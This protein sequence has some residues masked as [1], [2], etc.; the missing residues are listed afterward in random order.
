MKEK[1]NMK[2]LFTLCGRAGSKGC[3]NKNIRDFLGHP[4]FFYSIN[5]IEK[6][7]EKNDV[8]YRIG[9]STDSPDFINLIPNKEKIVVIKRSGDLAL[10]NTPKMAAIRDCALQVE[11]KYGFDYDLVADFDI[12]SPIRTIDDIQKGLAVFAE[13]DYDCVFSVTKARR[14]PYFNMVKCVDGVYSKAL[15]S[16]FTTRQQ[17]P[18]MFDMNASIYFY[19][20]EFLLN[21]ESYSPLQKR[22]AVFEMMDTGIIDIDDNEDFEMMEIIAKYLRDNNSEYNTILRLEE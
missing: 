8:D 6:F 16:T 22:F 10:D 12:T 1:S 18:K 17:A 14:N 21:P 5:A 7:C 11:N 19:K 4:L 15:E 3:K 2:I 20:K 9:I 13:G